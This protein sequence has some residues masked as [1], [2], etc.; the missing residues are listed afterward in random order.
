MVQFGFENGCQQTSKDLQLAVGENQL[1]IVK[2]LI[3]QN[4]LYKDNNILIVLA[5]THDS[6]EML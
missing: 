5:V 4:I 1:K 3:S 6:T 2:Y